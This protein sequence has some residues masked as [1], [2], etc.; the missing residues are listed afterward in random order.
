MDKGLALHTLVD[1]YDAR[2]V[3]FIGDD[4]GD[5]PAFEA[6]AELRSRGL[7][8]LLVCSGSDEE[9]TLR[10]L[11]D[12]VVAGPDGVMEFLRELTADLKAAR[13]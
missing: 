10:D 2:A 7:P 6:V 4:L 9:S 1:E 3:V 11:A 12:V 5:V 13:A 8:S